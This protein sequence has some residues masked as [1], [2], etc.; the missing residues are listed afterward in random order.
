MTQS[1]LLQWAFSCHRRNAFHRIVLVTS[2]LD[3][4][5]I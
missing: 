1:F 3:M 5:E 2:G 4:L